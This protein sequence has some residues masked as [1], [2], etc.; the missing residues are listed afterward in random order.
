MTSETSSSSRL[1]LLRER[2]VN[3]PA[4]DLAP[5]LSPGVQPSQPS[6]ASYHEQTVAML[7]TIAA[8]LNARVLLLLAVLGAFILTL[9][10]IFDPSNL[11][12]MAA[13]AFHLC[14][15]VP[16]VGLYALKG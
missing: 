11:K 3:D 8:V 5:T 15:V 13:L 14:V 7:A 9:V 6:A 10:T 12:L 16:L 2:P 1:R 4:V